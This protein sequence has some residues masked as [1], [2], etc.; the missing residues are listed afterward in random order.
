MNSRLLHSP[1]N[2]LV[3]KVQ[4]RLCFIVG[5]SGSLLNKVFKVA[6]AGIVDMVTGTRAV[7]QGD[8]PETAGTGQKTRRKRATQSLAS[9]ASENT[10]HPNVLA[11]AK[12]LQEQKLCLLQGF[13]LSQQPASRGQPEGW[14]PSPPSALLPDLAGPDVCLWLHASGD[15][16]TFEMA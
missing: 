16:G 1:S 5:N 9:S 10:P 4:T 6:P 14:P 13:V 12:G 7:R 8:R 2:T 11:R 3:P 15:R